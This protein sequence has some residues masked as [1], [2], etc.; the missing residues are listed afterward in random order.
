LD[1]NV[2]NPNHETTLFAANQTRLLRHLLGFVDLRNISHENICLLHTA[3]VVAIFTYRLHRLHTLLQ[4]ITNPEVEISL[5][6]IRFR[7]DGRRRFQVGLVTKGE[8]IGM[9]IASYHPARPSMRL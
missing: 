5:V 6:Q 8:T 7:T 2:D 9:T 1:G 4:D 3:V